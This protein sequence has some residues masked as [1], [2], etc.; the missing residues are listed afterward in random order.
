[1]VYGYG[2]RCA[3]PYFALLGR[4]EGAVPVGIQTDGNE[5]EPFW[6]CGINATYKEVWLSSATALLRS[7]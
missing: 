4:C 2:G 6:P 5:D 1:M 3:E 7:M